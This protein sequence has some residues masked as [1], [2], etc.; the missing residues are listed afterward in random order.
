MDAASCAADMSARG[1]MY[2]ALVAHMPRGF[3]PSR[4]SSLFLRGHNPHTTPH[5]HIAPPLRFQHTCS[6]IAY[7]AP[8]S[9]PTRSN[10]NRLVQQHFPSAPH[11]LLPATAWGA[12]ALTA[13][14][15]AIQ[16]RSCPSSSTPSRPRDV[17]FRKMDFMM[18]SPRYLARINRPLHTRGVGEGANGQRNLDLKLYWF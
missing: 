1:M 7:H 3:A 18:S 10:P 4:P 5:L 13:S 17:T 12:F 2:I 11:D 14:S 15:N 8:P 6:W 9:L 16:R